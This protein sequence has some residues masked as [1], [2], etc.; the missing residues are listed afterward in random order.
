MLPLS[1]CLMQ[2]IVA[3][4]NVYVEIGLI[5]KLSGLGRL[6]KKRHLIR[7]MLYMIIVVL[8]QTSKNSPSESK[9]VKRKSYSVFV[10]LEQPVIR[11]S[12]CDKIISIY[13]ETMR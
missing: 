9:I 10:I 8:F 11:N 5:N 4:V 3:N 13:H 12:E 7:L 2:C 6:P 1:A